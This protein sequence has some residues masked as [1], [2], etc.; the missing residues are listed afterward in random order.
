V[1]A[2]TVDPIAAIYQTGTGS[3]GCNCDAC[4]AGDDP[5]DWAGDDAGELQY[6]LIAKV[7]AIEVGY[8][9]DEQEA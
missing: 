5:A 1:I 2:G 6:E 3:F 9:D 4:E 7:D 8:F